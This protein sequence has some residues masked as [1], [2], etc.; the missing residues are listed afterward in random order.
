M[1][2]VSKVRKRYILGLTGG[3]GSGKSTVLSVFRQCGAAVS[4]G[5]WAGFARATGHPEWADDPRF[6][7]PTDRV[8]HWD[9]RLGL[10]AEALATRTTAE[11]I[12][13]LDAEQV[14]CA[15]ILKREDLLTDPQLAANELIVESDHPHVGR[16]RQTRPAA[17]F[18][19]TPA[20]IQRPA[21]RLGEHTD[22][23]LAEV[24]MSPSEIA[25]L[26]EVGAVS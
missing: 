25:R 16:L 2:A 19:R 14:P 11:W 1:P 23:L 12:E 6:K 18:D 22:E 20:G 21:P 10:M 7:T 17:R 4:D 8:V 24:G 15:P 9:T 3:M 13:R 26:R 5:E